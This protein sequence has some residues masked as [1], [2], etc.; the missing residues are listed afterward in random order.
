VQRDQ[1]GAVR[2]EGGEREGQ[3]GQEHHQRAAW[4]PVAS[5]FDFL[6]PHEH[7]GKGEGEGEDRGGDRDWPRKIIRNHQVRR[8]DAKP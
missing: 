8:H 5:D 2:Q 4:H 3:S 6:L 7:A 1:P